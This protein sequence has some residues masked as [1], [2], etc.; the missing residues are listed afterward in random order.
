MGGIFN[1][2]EDMMR[3]TWFAFFAVYN[4]VI[5]T[6]NPVLTEKMAQAACGSASLLL[7]A[8]NCDVGEI[9]GIVNRNICYWLLKNIFERDGILNVG[10]VCGNLTTAET[11]CKKGLSI[12]LGIVKFFVVLSKVC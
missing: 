12:F 6:G 9:K 8:G 2:A 11:V 3:H 7:G 5:I 1:R 4:R 10:Y